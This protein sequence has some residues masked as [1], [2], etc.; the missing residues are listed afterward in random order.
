MNRGGV[1]GVS[2]WSTKQTRLAV[3]FALASV[4]ARA[5][6]ADT[7]AAAS[8]AHAP[9]AARLAP[10]AGSTPPEGSALV[11]AI[12]AA[13]ASMAK[14]IAD[15][16]VV[17]SPVQSD[18]AITKP[19]ELARRVAART[20]ELLGQGAAPAASPATL[21][22]AEAALPRDRTLV[23]ASASI[24]GGRVRIV[25]D[26]YS[27]RRSFWQRVF[28]L[29]PIAEARVAGAAPLDAEVNG[30]LQP[31]TFGK[32]LLEKLSGA[33]EDWIALACGDIDQT[34]RPALVLLSRKRVALARVNG[35]LVRLLASQGLSALSPVAANPLREPLSGIGIR[36]GGLIDVGVTDRAAGLRLDRS[37]R[38][39]KSFERR[40]PWPIHGCS[41]LSGVWLSGTIEP[42]A[43]ADVGAKLAVF[44]E[45]I[46]ALA[47]DHVVE[48]DGR[49]RH[50][51]AARLAS[52]E[53]LEL[54]DDAGRRMQADKIGA[55]LALADL[56]LDG[57]PEVVT[58]SSSRDPREDALTIRTWQKSGALLERARIPMPDGVRALT[59]CTPER[60]GLRALLVAA[61][62]ELWA[63]Q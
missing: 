1:N 45:A 28:N 41:A 13:L 22:E 24:A 52:S 29:G 3:L 5:T 32:P 48:P 59:V 47:A 25:L 43:G 60:H 63:V 9:F 11:R 37:L 62:N 50:Y 19:E 17:A 14:P 18:S 8:R 31:I 20:A 61:G 12:C 38:P 6:G 23:L 27:G 16:R 56:D 44:T 7:R 58:T 33:P 42:C 57:E 34:A 53:R 49:V 30:F 21:A 35:N 15:A 55:Q 4:S 10:T 36:E 40:I 26:V 51:Y 46:D 2:G 54:R 39:V